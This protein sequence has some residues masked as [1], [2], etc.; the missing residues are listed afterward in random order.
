MPD[1]NAPLTPE[2]TAH[3]AQLPAKRMGSGALIRDPEG[4]VLLVEPTYKATWEIPGGAVERDE[5]PRTAC[6]R[7]LREELGLEVVVGRLLVHEWQGPEPDRTESVMHVYDG[8]VLGSLDGVRLPP[9]ELASCRF[10]AEP[11]LDGLLATRLARRVRAALAALEDGVLVEL[12][13]G[14]R[15]DR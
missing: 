12:E 3:V 15:V 10:V 4:R 5:S 2:Q 6:R 8:G 14:A 13:N 1:P 9:D 7:E 11:D